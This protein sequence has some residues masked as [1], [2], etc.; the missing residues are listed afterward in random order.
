MS[1][2]I[3]DYNKEL[4][5][6]KINKFDFYKHTIDKDEL[7]RAYL[8]LLILLQRLP[9]E[10]SVRHLKYLQLYLMRLILIF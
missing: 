3:E 10:H 1:K 9:A 7:L 8:R 5:S 6:L 2:E 4:K